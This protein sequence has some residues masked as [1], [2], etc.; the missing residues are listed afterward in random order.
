MAPSRI[1]CT[2][3]SVGPNLCY[4]IVGGLTPMVAI[5]TI[6]RSGDDF[7]PAFL[8]MATATISFVVIARYAR[9]TS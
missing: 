8:L 2:V 5:Y 6:K 9:P 4:G 7:S 3:A 1:R